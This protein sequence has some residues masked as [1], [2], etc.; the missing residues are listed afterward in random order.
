MRIAFINS[1][2]GLMY[3]DESRV[4][5]YK[6]AG[7]MPAASVVDSTAEIVDVEEPKPRRRRTKKED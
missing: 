1:V 6:A 3:V 4:E 7:F 2:G 5:E